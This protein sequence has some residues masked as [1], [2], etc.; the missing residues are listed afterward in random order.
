MLQKKRETNDNSANNDVEQGL[1]IN[2][3]LT[4]PVAASV[5]A[6]TY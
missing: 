3:L 1:Q 4:I 6:K 5:G 2:F